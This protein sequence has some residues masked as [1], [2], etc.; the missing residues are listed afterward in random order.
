VAQKIARHSP[1]P[2]VVLREKSPGSS[3]LLHPEETRPVCALVALD[4][5]PFAEATLIPTAKLVAVFSQLAV[6]GV[7]HLVR[8]VKPPGD[9]EKRK[10]Q[11]YD[12]N[13]QEYNRNEAEHY[14]RTTRERL[15]RELVAGLNLQ[16]TFSVI[17]DV[18]IATAL[19]GAAEK[20]DSTDT[21]SSNGYDLIALATHGRGGIQRWMIG[22]IAERL[23]EESK[24][25][26]LIVRP[27]E[28]VT[29]S[30]STEPTSARP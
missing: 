7:L 20:G 17:E 22:S 8:V 6:P 18:D 27:L 12:V 24:L 1:V 11:V 26:M 16:V 3:S 25:P 28:L 10:Y 2:V 5:S 15:S 21:Q 13:I 9:T 23:L 29:T 4:G 19:I 14:L 30:P